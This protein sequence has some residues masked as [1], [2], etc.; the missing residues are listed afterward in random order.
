MICESSGNQFGRL[1]KKVDIFFL[2]IRPLEKILDPSL[3]VYAASVH[4][5]H[6]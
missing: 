2:K 6:V 4:V 3:A 1:I 5:S